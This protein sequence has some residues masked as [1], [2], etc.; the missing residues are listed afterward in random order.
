MQSWPVLIHRAGGEVLAFGFQVER[1][2][3]LFV[4]GDVLAQDVPQ[5]FGLLRT[6]EDGLVVADGDLLGAFA[7]GEAEDELEVPYAYAY[8]HAVGVGLT[9][10]WRLGK[11][12]LRLLRTLAH[13][14]SLPLCRPACR[15]PLAYDLKVTGQWTAFTMRNAAAVRFA[16]GH[17]EGVELIEEAHEDGGGIG[18]EG[19]PG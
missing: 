3:G 17:G 13:G 19:L 8:L 16:H 1:A 14:F 4:L 9:V 2:E 7:G 6:E 18:G 15:A 10:V 12:Q 5:G 11:I